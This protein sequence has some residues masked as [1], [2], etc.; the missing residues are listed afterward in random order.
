MTFTADNKPFR[1]EDSGRTARKD[2]QRKT[3]PASRAVD[4]PGG[5]DV[6]LGQP[7]SEAERH[8][9]SSLR[10]GAWRSPCST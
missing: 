2:S 6:Q 8:K 9:G 5:D 3:V 4:L 7:G 10:S 1:S